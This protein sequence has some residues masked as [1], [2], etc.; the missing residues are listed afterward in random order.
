MDCK[1]PFEALV[2]VVHSPEPVGEPA[3]GLPPRPL[4]SRLTLL[5]RHCCTTRPSSRIG[6]TRRRNGGQSGGR[7][8]SFCLLRVE[9]GIDGPRISLVLAHHLDQLGRHERPFGVYFTPWYA[10]GFTSGFVAQ[11][12][13]VA[14]LVP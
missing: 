4:H 10:A 9:L 8:G 11:V 1:L 13:R 3:I 6:S 2:R 5:T 12:T 7:S 14:L